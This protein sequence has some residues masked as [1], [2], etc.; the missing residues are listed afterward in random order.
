MQGLHGQ[1]AITGV[2]P[3]AGAFDDYTGD[4]ATTRSYHV[5]VCR[6]MDDGS[7]SGVS[8]WRR[9]P[10][11][12]LMASGKDLCTETG[13]PYHIKITKRGAALA[14]FV[15]DQPGPSFTDPDTLPD[16]LPTIG[17]V[18]FRAIG[19]KATFRIS[20]FKVTPLIPNPKS[21]KSQISLALPQA[22]P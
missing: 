7:H 21:P 2:P 17:K 20:N 19:S 22:L 12:H 9:N 8:N 14:I 15:N 4:D 18:G 13:K 10:G 3:R 11:L 1:D 5:S 16:Q 6:Y